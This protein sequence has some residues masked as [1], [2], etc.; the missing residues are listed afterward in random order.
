MTSSRSPGT[1]RQRV[2]SLMA[3]AAISRE[4]AVWGSTSGGQEKSPIGSDT[5]VSHRLTPGLRQ[6]AEAI[7][8]SAADW[9]DARFSKSIILTEVGYSI[10]HYVDSDPIRSPARAP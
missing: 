7:H 1:Y 9:M 4:M 5:R 8:P 10:R 6:P 2:H 3:S